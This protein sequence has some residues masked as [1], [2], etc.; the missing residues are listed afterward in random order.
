[1]SS[2]DFL[3]RLRDAAALVMDACEG[4]LEKLGPQGLRQAT[5]KEETFTC[6]KFESQQGA[7]IGAYE[8]AYK[9]NNTENLWN[10]AYNILKQSNAVI[11]HRYHGEDY[12]FSYWL[13]T[14]NKIYRQKLK[15]EAA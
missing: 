2:V 6:L 9:A 7:K 4:E 10:D 13:F 3:V 14:E 15:T 1:M 12:V 8:V 5:V 11:R